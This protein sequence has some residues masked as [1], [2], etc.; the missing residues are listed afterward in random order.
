MII[1]AERKLAKIMGWRKGTYDSPSFVNSDRTIQKSCWY[2][3]EGLRQIKSPNPLE[4][5]S[6]DYDILVWAKQD[7]TRLWRFGCALATFWLKHTD[8]EIGYY[9]KTAC[10]MEGIEQHER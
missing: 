9:F 6:D 7:E 5:I 10:L 8:Y 3:P 4:D 1:E 2:N